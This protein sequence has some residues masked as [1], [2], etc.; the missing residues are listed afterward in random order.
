MQ[1]RKTCG[2]NEIQATQVQDHAAGTVD[3]LLHVGGELIGVGGVE[4]AVD[5][6]QG[7]GQPPPR[8]ELCGAALLPRLGHR[9][10]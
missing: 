2:A 4:F 6:D 7:P 9:H 5:G 10:R 3:A 1:G 8:R